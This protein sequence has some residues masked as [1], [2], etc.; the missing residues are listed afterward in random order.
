MFKNQITV[1][2]RGPTGMPGP[3]GKDGK[4][5]KG[6]KGDRGKDGTNGTNGKDGKDAISVTG[7]TG[8]KGDKGKDGT[9]GIDGQFGGPTGP[10]GIQGEEGKSIIGPTGPPGLNGSPGKDIII[11]NDLSMYSIKLMHNYNKIIK[12]TN[13]FLYH[14]WE[15]M[16][17]GALCI[18]MLTN[19]NKY[20]KNITLS[21]NNYTLSFHITGSEPIKC[22]HISNMGQL[23]S[24]PICMTNVEVVD[25]YHSIV[26]FN[27]DS[28]QSYDEYVYYGT[29]YD[30]YVNWF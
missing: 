23:K 15:N 30:I 27:F 17:V 25:E 19:S 2:P 1:G 3:P 11:Y 28:Q 14:N 24:A 7:P 5:I 21:K 4:T 29:I 12:D 10:T 20:I 8:P 16:D 26:Y 6:E 13:I 9:N 18:K 22:I